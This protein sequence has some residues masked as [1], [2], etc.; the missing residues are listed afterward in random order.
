MGEV[1]PPGR[2]AG[3]TAERRRRRW[4]ML[5]AVTAAAVLLGAVGVA[6]QLG[7]ERPP[8]SGSAAKG[9]GT[10]VPAASETL[11]AAQIAELPEARYNTVIAGL[12]P[13]TNASVPAASAAAYT[14]SE[15][16]PIYSAARAPV[17]RFAF[18]NFSNRPTVI[19][20]VR[21]EGAWALVMTPARQVLPSQAN[22]AAPAQ[23]AGWVRT[24]VLR[25]VTE[26]RQRIVLSVA[27][28]KLSIETLAGHVQESFGVGVGTAATPTP[29]GVTGYLQERYLDPKQGES[30]YPI[31][32]TSLH[33]ASQDEPFQGEDGGLIGIHYFP[34]HSGSVSHGC[35]RL[36]E[37]A[38][39]SVNAL[40][41]GTSI[42][43]V[44]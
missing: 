19:V 26:L 15:D 20:P 35:I 34:V 31:N 33:S 22:G 30:T 8:T 3:R 40:P 13:Y 1:D 7:V 21:I 2:H 12:I 18:T 24:S 36:P 17:A 44:P 9:E 4:F 11:T 39:K 10:I 23:T 42:T 16:V 28:R 37:D 32:L 25:K 41:L 29:T 6:A 38:I 43:I 14:I 27:E 5:G